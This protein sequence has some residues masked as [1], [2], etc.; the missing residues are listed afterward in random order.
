MCIK[1]ALQNQCISL[2]T[3]ENTVIIEVGNAAITIESMVLY[4]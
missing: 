1:L 4:H 2:Y 3:S